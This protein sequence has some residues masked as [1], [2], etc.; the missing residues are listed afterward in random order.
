MVS[1]LTNP[2]ASPEQL[3]SS[4]SHSDGLPADLEVSL[5]WA[6]SSLI[7]SAGILLRL[8]QTT[9][10]TAIILL[11]RFYLLASFRSFSVLHTA[12][13][14]LY[15][16]SKLTETPTKPR[17]II[18]VTTYILRMPSPSPVSP[19]HDG[20]TAAANPEQFY[21]DENLYFQHRTRL[22]DIET[23]IL[24][25]VG[26]QTHTALPY[27]LVVNYAQTLECLD[28]PL[29]KRSF[30]YLTDALLSPS[31]VYLT[32][33]PNALAVAALYLA[34]RDESVKLPE[35]WW[36]I[37]DVEREDLGFLV[38]VMRGVGSFVGE[39]VK[40]WRDDIGV[41]PWEASDLEA[42]MDRR[43]ILS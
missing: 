40:A 25:A 24:K 7:Q 41:I 19:K 13:A 1:F 39:Q 3:V 2:I 5:R 9:I 4:P 8:P 43:R 20:K 23:Q 29:L 6:G 34:A 22:L 30:G 14:A 15:L 37:F 17:S 21:V 33:Q 32:H 10:A 35:S 42:E 11:Q 38:A 12:H 28:K 16:A 18:N 36:D 31:L 26:Y 27:T